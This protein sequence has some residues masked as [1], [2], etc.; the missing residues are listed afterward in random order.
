MSLLGY[1]RKVRLSSAIE[2]RSSDCR[3]TLKDEDRLEWQLDRFNKLWQ[4]TIKSVPYYA[5]LVRDKNLPYKFSSWQEFIENVPITKKEIVDKRRAEMTDRSR[6][7]DFWRTTGGTTSQP[8][9]LPAW[10]SEKVAT[11][12]DIWVARKWYDINPDSRLFMIWGH[13]H[14]LGTGFKGRINAISRNLKDWLLDYYRFSAYD[15]NPAVLREAGKKMLRYRPDYVVGYS[16]ALDGFACANKDLTPEFRNLGLKVVIGAAESFPNERSE[17]IMSHLFGCPVAMEYGSVE[18]NLMGHTH[19]SGGYIVFWKSH[20]LEA[21]EDG[22]A[23]GRILRI[24]SLYPRCFPLIRYEIGDQIVTYAG[25]S[26]LGLWRFKKVAGRCNLFILLDDGTRVHSEAFTHCVR[27]CSEIARYQVIQTK[28]E[29][30]L[31][32]VKKN[33]YSKLTQEKIRSKLSKVHPHLHRI[34]FEVVDKLEKTVA[35]KTPM[36][37]RQ[38]SAPI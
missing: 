11:N 3:K 6:K 17:E 27:D 1:V 25:D 21:T 23:N 9:Q 24:T 37:I 10:N 28:D 35:G 31:L 29:I 38:E 14:L 18:T 4:Q 5:K 7:P 33:G 13:S 30:R 2:D 34:K 36:I 19:P 16:V 20:F 32:I 12:P 26:G 8:I 22:T 15:M